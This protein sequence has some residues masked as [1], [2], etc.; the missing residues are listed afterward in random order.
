MGKPLPN[1]GGDDLRPEDGDRA[2]AVVTGQ[3]TAAGQVSSPIPIYGAFNVVM[4]G[5][6]AGSL[7][8]GDGTAKASFDDTDSL[9]AGL[10]A[11]AGIRTDS[12][13]LPAG[14]T[15]AS[16]G[17]DGNDTVNVGGLTTVQLGGLT[18]SQIAGLTAGTIEVELTGIGIVPTATIVLERSFDGG[19][20][21]I[22]CNVG[23][24]G[25]PAEY[26][27]GSSGIT[28]P[29]SFVVGE[30]E[31]VINYRLNCTSFTSGV[32]LE[33]RISTTGLAALAWGVT[34]I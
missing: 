6:L 15:F 8:L 23:S 25:Q 27:F 10:V 30:P 16:V 2:N 3:F 9:A 26:E 5:V 13:V 4:Y 24:V 17:H 34:P 32:P 28:N 18:T 12:D 29:V 1:G 21:W 11:G 22:P 33:Y 31:V 7:I 20:T 14:A 19:E